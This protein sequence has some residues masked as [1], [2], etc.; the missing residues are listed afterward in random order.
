MSGRLQGC[1]H[2]SK[3]GVI[4]ICVHR[5]HWLVCLSLS[6]SVTYILL[7]YWYEGRSINSRTVLLSKHTVTVENQNYDE[8]LWPL[9]YITFRDVFYDHYH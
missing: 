1:Y 3:A 4:A 9:L 5:R 2:H 7:M 6:F 8:V